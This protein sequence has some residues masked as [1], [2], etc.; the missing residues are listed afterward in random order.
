[1]GKGKGKHN[2]KNSKQKLRSLLGKVV[3]Q[4]EKFK[5]AQQHVEKISKK[6]KSVRQGMHYCETETNSHR[7]LSV[8]PSKR[9]GNET[10]NF[11]SSQY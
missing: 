11:S 2:A 4:G 8:V 6:K 10:R 5:K 1:M 9:A 3:N 7:M